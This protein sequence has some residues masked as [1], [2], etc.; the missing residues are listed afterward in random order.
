MYSLTVQKPNSYVYGHVI[1]DG[2]SPNFQGFS[3]LIIVHDCGYEY[4]PFP[5][6][7]AHRCA[8]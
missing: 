5:T 7:C 6:N 4:C 8:L 3:T 2:C 1:A